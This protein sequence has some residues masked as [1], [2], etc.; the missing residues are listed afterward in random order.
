VAVATSGAG[1]ELAHAPPIPPDMSVDARLLV[2]TADGTDPAY[3]A[4]TEALQY[5]GTPFDSFNASTE[6]DLTADR[7]ATGNHGK[8][9]GVILDTGA[10][11]TGSTSAFSAAE[12]AV[13]ADYEAQ[14]QVRRVALY[15][16]PTATY[17]L[18]GSGGFDTTTTPLSIH[19]TASGAAVFLD[20]NCSAGVTVKNAWA[21]P[22]TA[23][24]TT[25]V[26]ILV[27]DGGRIFG[28]TFTDTVGHEYLAL[29]F[30]QAPSLVHSLSLMYDVVR[31]VTRGVFLGERHV[32]VTSQID[33]LF[34][35]SDIY[36]YCSDC[37]DGGALG[38]GAVSSGDDG[39]SSAGLTYRI[40]DL[41][42][43][44]LAN[45]QL[46]PRGQPLT[47]GLRLNWALNGVGS[48]ATDPLTIRAQGLGSTFAW[49]SHTWDH[50]DLDG[51]SYADA[52]AEFTQND[53]RVSSMG[54]QPYDLRNIV[55]PSV[56]GL[57]NPDAMRAAFDAGIRFTVSDTSVSGWDNPS[58]N[59]GIYSLEESAILII[60]RRPTNL[61]YNVSTPDVW[62]QEYNDIYRSY[63][64]RDLTYDEILD[65][66]SEVLLQYLLRGE[67]DPWMFHQ[68][69]T[70]DYGGG[71]SLLSDLHD[72]A[73]AKY[74]ALSK[75]PI[76]SDTLEVLGGR[77]AMRMS[78]DKAQ[79]SAVIGPGAQIT[80]HVTRGASVPVTG[81]CTPSA[82]S[83][84]GQKISYLQLAA[85]AEATFSLD[86]CND[87]TGGSGGGMAGSGGGTGGG[88]GG[89][90]GGMAGSGGG[91][92]GSMAGSGG[93]MAGSGGGTGGGTGG[94]G[95]GSG[96][97]TGG[98]GGG[99]TGGSSPGGALGTGD[100]GGALGTGGAAG[101]GGAGGSGATGGSGGAGGAAG[102]GDAGGSGATGGSAGGGGAAGTGDAGGAVGTGGSGAA[103][104]DAGGSG[105]AGG[106]AGTGDAGG[107]GGT[108]GS[109]TASDAGG[110]A[111][112]AGQVPPAPS[113]NGGCGC[114]LAE[115]SPAA[116]AFGLVF[117]TTALVTRRRRRAR[118]SAKQ[119][120]V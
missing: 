14:F 87:G 50:T 23:T 8:Y 27:D 118:A 7:L 12:W 58:P 61:F 111:P 53:A 24:G 45:W 102:T 40:T 59:A 72:R 57:D 33:D 78:Y 81:L 106:A 16:Y 42:L 86:G 54:L 38:E 66:E 41:D 90:G 101:T 19:C 29:T 64:R 108:G 11:S 6:P 105:G 94:S 30:A 52:L 13:L 96:G 74:G 18:A 22:A 95:D 116:S 120:E 51:M 62:Q 91:A 82:E 47:G 104:S 67:N 112:D 17:G 5:L 71:R 15:A 46:G 39:G 10:L 26:P 76:V 70:R 73:L 56:S 92:G 49:I 35:A 28:A 89:S 25:T 55:T 79:A 3:A 114:S 84:A 117:V 68:A 1:L 103:A 115:K 44:A 2:I 36:P 119:E 20:T 37:V 31:W 32:Y 63:W 110:S 107:A 43:Q 4:I 93:G 65:F 99:G 80:V 98:S 69:N 21:Y 88:T 109:G 75:F 60:P 77:V 48:A 100:T 34:L 9:Y 97:G 113:S 85:G 83:Y